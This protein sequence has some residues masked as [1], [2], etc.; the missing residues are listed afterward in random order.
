MEKND[1]NGSNNQNGEDDFVFS[2]NA[3]GRWADSAPG[4]SPAAEGGA[5]MPALE[6]IAMDVVEEELERAERGEGVSDAAIERIAEGGEGASRDR[7]GMSAYERK[8]EKR[9]EKKRKREEEENVDFQ[10]G[11]INLTDRVKNKSSQTEMT[12]VATLRKEEVRNDAK[13]SGRGH[14][15]GQPKSSAQKFCN[16]KTFRNRRDGT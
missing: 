9:E 8:E 2:P 15:K 6:P 14:L 10:T 3:V 4:A 7:S 12:K 1:N 16:G 11:S 5:E 13:R